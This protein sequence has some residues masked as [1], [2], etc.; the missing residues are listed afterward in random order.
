MPHIAPALSIAAALSLALVAATAPAG[1]ANE[2]QAQCGVETPCEIANGE[3]RIRFPQGWD[4]N[5]PLGAIVFLH[6]WRGSAAGE[7]RNAAWAR[8]AD[9]L[10]VAFVAPQG[11]GKTWSYPG[12]PRALRDDFAFF[13]ALVEDLT[14]RFPLRADRMMATGFSMGGSMVWNLAC[15]R[16]RLFAGFAPIAGAFWDPIPETCPSPAPVLFHVHGTADRTVPL[17]GRPIGERWHQSD[18]ADSLAV[19]QA[20]AG[21]P[22]VFPAFAP[23]TGLNCQLQ[24]ARKKGG[25]AT[26]LLEVCL[27]SGGHS[28]RA[29]WVERAWRAL[30]RHLG[31]TD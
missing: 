13:D 11:A 19:W 2:P 4:G 14:A 18:V 26:P 23:D 20:Q 27:H 7:M 29:E 8:L 12:A 21:L 10:N 3:Y 9:R 17:E 25:G 6:G 5:S 31:W 28:V 15:Y 30:A 16:G 24:E 22:R 1:A